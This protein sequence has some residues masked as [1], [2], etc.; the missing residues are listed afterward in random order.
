MSNW[1][2]ISAKFTSTCYICEDWINKGDTAYWK[3]ITGIKHYPE[4]PNFEIPDEDKTELIIQEQDEE[5]Y[6]K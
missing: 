1:I 5:F 2:I 6:L 4:C 3:K